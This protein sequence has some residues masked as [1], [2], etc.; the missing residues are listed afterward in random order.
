MKLRGL[1]HILL[2]SDLTY[3]K[4]LK[5]II[6]LI[7]P[8]A[9]GLLL[10]LGLKQYVISAN[11]VH[12]GSMAPNLKTGQVLTTYRLMDIKH[13]SVIIFNAHGEDP[14]ATNK[15][16][17]YVKRVIGL[18]GDTVESKNGQIYVNGKAINQSYISYYQRTKGSG[19]W[20]LESLSTSWQHNQNVS[21]VPKGKYFV[22]G[23]HRT[24]SNDSRYWGGV[25]KDK[26]NG[27]TKAF[28]FQKNHQKVNDEEAVN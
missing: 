19:N 4:V 15:T 27:V 26:V 25:D 21:R 9:I 18:P 10:G 1:F 2:R 23:D 22:L 17:L 11:F 24:I 13:N 14:Q 3:M 6:S 5:G 20:D 8:I 12:G 16:E 7:V 28:P